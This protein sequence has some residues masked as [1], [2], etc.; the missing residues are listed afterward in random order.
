VLL[1]QSTMSKIVSGTVNL[2]WYHSITG[3][4]GLQLCKA[5]TV[6][7]HNTYI[8]ACYAQGNPK[9]FKTLMETQY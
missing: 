5:H 7:N 1:D 8:T 2:H 4:K 6:D 3:N 9:T